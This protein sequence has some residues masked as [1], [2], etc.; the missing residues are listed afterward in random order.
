M[1][2]SA[3]QPGLGGQPGQPER[4]GGQSG[5]L[6]G[7]RHGRTLGREQSEQLLQRAEQLTGQTLWEAGEAGPTYTYRSGTGCRG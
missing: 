7:R 2:V 3:G 1:S 6:A 4:Q 5:L